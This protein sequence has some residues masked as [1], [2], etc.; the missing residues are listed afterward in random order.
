MEQ[1]GVQGGGGEQNGAIAPLAPAPAPAPAL[2]RFGSPLDRLREHYLVQER[3]DDPGVYD[4]YC[5]NCD[6]SYMYRSGYGFGVFHRHSNSQHGINWGGIG[7]RG[8]GRG[9]GRA[10]D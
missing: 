6:I 8:R 3:D 4:A 5:K 10:R 1:D 7:L 2:R 9:R